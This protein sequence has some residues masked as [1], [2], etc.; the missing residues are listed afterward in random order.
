MF[1][2][3][4]AGQELMTSALRAR[5]SESS[6]CGRGEPTPK[7]TSLGSEFPL[8]S[9]NRAMSL[10]KSLSQSEPPSPLF[11]KWDPSILLSGLL[12]GVNEKMFAKG[13]AGGRHHI[14]TSYPVFMILLVTVELG[15]HQTT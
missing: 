1:P 14:G 9:L 6:E 3:A 12:R 11:L 13:L 7:L 2:L 15:E 4:A 8:L 5:E 10:S